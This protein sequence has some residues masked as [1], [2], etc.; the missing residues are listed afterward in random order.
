MEKCVKKKRGKIRLILGFVCMMVGI[1]YF[2]IG[3]LYC[4]HFNRWM[5]L[6]KLIIY[7]CIGVLII[8]LEIFEMIAFAWRKIFEDSDPDK[9]S[10]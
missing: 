4:V 5:S 8:K 9:P 1:F 10:S 3:V 7:G 6:L 2:A